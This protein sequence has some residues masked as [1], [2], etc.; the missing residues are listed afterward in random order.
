MYLYA[1]IVL[2]NFRLNFIL[3]FTLNFLKLK[4]VSFILKLKIYKAKSF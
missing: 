3:K 2:L 1:H 4:I